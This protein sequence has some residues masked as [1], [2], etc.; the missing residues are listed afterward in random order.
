MNTISASTK[1]NATRDPQISQFAGGLCL[2]VLLFLRSAP[3]GAATAAEQE[4]RTAPMPHMS[5][6]TDGKPATVHLVRLVGYFEGSPGNAVRLAEMKAKVQ[7]CVRDK[8]AV[9]MAAHPPTEW[10][11]HD[12]N[13]RID[14]YSSINRTIEY[15][16]GLTYIVNIAD[17]SLTAIR[18]DKASLFS[19]KGT[20]E[21]ELHEKTA[22]G[23]CDSDGQANAAPPV[24]RAA[25]TPAQMREMERQAPHDPGVAALLSA[26]RQY[27]PTD[28]GERK[29]IL[30]LDC[31]VQ[32]NLFEPGGTVCLS[33]GGSFVA[34]CATG[35]LSQSSM[36]LELVSP[37]GGK[38][39][40][41]VA[42]LDTR[43][44]GAVFVPYMAGGFRVTHSG[45]R[46]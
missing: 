39:E 25:I 13:M 17:C 28:T 6:D 5:M 11:D 18:R 46:R 34:Q 40:A 10:P 41:T 36:G 19:S 33:R 3:A 44:N 29:V 14:R 8:Q 32:K 20:C 38:M 12:M 35:A 27:G 26:T 4:F 1:R 23:V 15:S 43:V 9:G 21:I 24:R 45:T 31:D 30:G 22:H 16:S 37:V 7:Q 42:Q 2:L